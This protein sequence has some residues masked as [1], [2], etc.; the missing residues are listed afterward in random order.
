MSHDS[1]LEPTL[2][3][4]EPAIRFVPERHLRQVLQYLTD[5]GHALPAHAGLPYWFSRADLTDADV[6]TRAAMAGT[7]PRLLLV[8]DP[9][10]R[11]IEHKP[12]A[13]QLR[14]Y[15]RVLFRAAVMDA[16]DQ[17]LAS[18]KLKPET[19]S[20]RLNAFGP[21]AAREIRYVLEN[22]HF[23]SP[24]ASD[25]DRYRVFAAVYLDLDH[26][27]GHAVEEF[28]PALPSGHAVRDLLS[29][30]IAVTELVKAA[31]P[32][33]SADPERDPPA[34]ELWSK[35]LATAPVALGIAAPAAEI[36]KRL[37]RAI[38]A[39]QNGNLVRA[40]IL[41]TQA[42]EATQGE[43]RE[44]A[45]TGAL[46]ALGQLVDRLGK[47][48]EW[49]HET[50]QEWRQALGPLLP[51]AAAGIWT[52]AARCLYEIQRIPADLAREV[53]AVDLP[54]AI[55]T[56][57]RRPLRRHLP[58]ARPV[59]VLMAFHKAHKQLLRAG[60]G[61]LEQLRLD[62]LMY[63]ERHRREHGIRHTFTPIIVGALTDAG[64]VPTNRVEEVARDKLT[65]ELLD[66]VCDRGFLR[67]G[68]LRDAI[69]R[70]R[71]KLPDLAG[72]G[73]FFTGDGLLRADRNLSHALDGVYRRGEVYLRW[74]QK[75]SSV[76]FGTP[77][78]RWLT[79][80]L[81]LPFGGALFTLM[82]VEE[83]RHL[84]GKVAGLVSNSFAPKPRPQF[85]P[86]TPGTAPGKPIT[87]VK[88][89]WEFDEEE[90]EFFEHEAATPAEF[91]EETLDYVIRDI[92]ERAEIAVGVFR[93]SAAD[94]KPAHWEFDEKTLEF[95][96]APHHGPD[97][98]TWPSIL[99]LG[100]VLLFMFHVPPFRRAVFAALAFLW[101]GVRGVL[102]DVPHAVW[103]SRS[104]RAIRLSGTTRF[105]H[106][107][108]SS[109]AF[110]TLL[111]VGVLFIFGV[112]AR[113]LLWWGPAWF[114]ALVL[115]YNHPYG[116]LFQDRIAEA[117]SDWWRLVRVNLIPGLF[118]SIIDGFRMLANWVERQLYAV[119][120]W[121]RFRGGDSQ[122]S[123]AMKAV[124][125]LV[126]FPIAYLTRFA[127]YLLLE[128][129]VNPVKH[130]PVV[131]VGH[132][133]VWPTLPALAESIGWGPATVIINGCPGIF[134]FVA[135]ELKEN[136]R[137][138]RANRSPVLKPV[139]LGSHGESMRGLLRPGFHS[140][141]VP[142]L[143]RKARHAL[144]KGDRAEAA[145]LHHELDHAA[146][147][148]HRFVERELLP[149]MAGSANWGGVAVEVGA[150]HFGCQSAE[151]ELVAPALGRDPFVITF[152]N[153]GGLIEASIQL[154]GWA[155]QLTE[156]QRGVLTFALRG[157]L[158]MGAT[159]RFGNRE[160]TTEGTPEHGF[161]ALDRRVTW[162][163]W[164]DLWGPLPNVP[165][166][167]ASA[168]G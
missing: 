103:R 128:P 26:F 150:V 97:L 18:E 12:R 118:G 120:E 21:G 74:I 79:L 164:A 41:R 142:R 167:P 153:V 126:W 88:W 129:Q 160:R 48:L 83:L 93:S 37:Q 75:L 91:D 60:L 152:E 145:R 113:W 111:V 42:A 32:Q 3:A 137:L 104:L 168:Q 47:V 86:V 96:E 30:G 158:D 6:L 155:N 147:G 163:E 81:L 154:L 58:Y 45:V 50:R 90:L 116:W 7:E 95:Y 99:G 144:D 159:A 9:N 31:R 4:V 112:P 27:T 17:Q 124:L 38:D 16:I 125:G 146:E 52:R 105:L 8:T 123:L 133:V 76:F 162:A 119:D 110:L 141:T 87:S 134:G 43:A 82:V 11:L 71:L 121:M 25:I 130:F 161:S 29:D 109:P 69:A 46:S 92:G 78:G 19:C 131:T 84:G 100:T 148:V 132:K 1:S 33:G 165:V 143:H 108:I 65:A 166:I 102:W 20:E 59:M 136:W 64:L 62:R 15:W 98:I 101:R 68:N 34:D 54:E 39:E 2:R 49:D 66:R 115:A 44:Q 73:E 13:E 157:L 106:R 114:A 56:L 135:W 51:L 61:E 24:D 138:Y 107:H 23:A 80:Y 67:I 149:L 94:K 35:T 22:E 57:G 127:F 63:H 70:N 140:G 72:V 151:V 117:L 5:R 14:V 28:F 89:E 122:G 10:D 40:A 85:S 77:W 55:R 53:Y 156:G 36:T 139:M